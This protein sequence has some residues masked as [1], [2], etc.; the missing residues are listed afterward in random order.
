MNRPSQTASNTRSISCPGAAHSTRLFDLSQFPSLVS[1]R[2]A[3]E[4]P[5]AS[6]QLDPAVWFAPRLDRDTESPCDPAVNAQ[7]TEAHILPSLVVLAAD[8]RMEGSVLLMVDCL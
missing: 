2:E 4:T 6:A 3:T 1:F 8:G 5:V 7:R